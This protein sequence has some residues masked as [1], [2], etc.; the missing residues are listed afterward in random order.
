MFGVARQKLELI[1][2]KKR[3]WTQEQLVVSS[4]II[5]K[6]SKV[7][8]FYYPNHSIRKVETGNVRFIENGEV[9]GS[10]EPRKVE[11]KEVRVRVSLSLLF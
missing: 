4:L 9:C 11:I 6:K 1:T 7:F 8:K 2:N 5:Q 3:N 10:D